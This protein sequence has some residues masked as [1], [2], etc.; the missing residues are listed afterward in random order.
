MQKAEGKSEE[1]RSGIPLFTFAFCILTS[2]F[3]FS[4]CY[5]IPPKGWEFADPST[6]SSRVRVAFVGKSGW[7]FSP[8]VNLAIEN[9]VEGDIE[10]YLQQ[11]KE[12]HEKTPNTRWRDLGPFTTLS[13]PARLTSVDLHSP[14]GDARL[15]QLIF[16]KDKVAYILTAT[17]GKEE[18][19]KLQKEFEGALHSFR[20]T[21][22]LL[23]NLSESKQKEWQKMRQE[24]LVKW[25]EKE[26]DFDSPQAH[27]EDKKFQKSHWLPFQ[28]KIV[29]EGKE[30]GPYGQ[31]LF[32]YEVQSEL[33]KT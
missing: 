33:K 31:L 20:L 14:R 17:A 30:L 11:V 22:N 1:R 5:F 25:K 7:G 24:I 18:F 15:L 2:A 13:G 28:K 6:L 19:F 23:E 29:K 10:N 8:S 26:A 32:L 3:L 9:E 12:I 21:D 4:Y 27:F 16:L